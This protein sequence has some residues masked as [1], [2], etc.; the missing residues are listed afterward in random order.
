VSATRSEGLF[1]HEEVLLLSLKDKVGTLH[2]GTHYQHA[3]SAAIV[4]ELL[5][6]GR[7]RVVEDGTKRF[8]E[9]SDR[10][11]LGDDVLDECLERI[12]AAKRRG[13][14]RRWVTTFAGVRQLKRR[15]AESLVDRGILKIGRD[16]VLLVFSR[17]IYPERDPKPER[18]IVKRL[19]RAIFTP[20]RDIDPRTAV[21]AAIAHATGILPHVFDKKRL[22][23][24]KKR[25]KDLTDGSVVGEATR[26]VV[27]AMHA[28]VMVASVAATTA[29]AGR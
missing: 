27:Q 4:A 28:A 11:P 20:A 9:V 8:V 21:L 22:K 25:L 26:D 23:D 14:V 19:R 13:Q 24:R 2:F 17:T 29:A 7:I 12:A 6:G 3:M 15:V 1:L 18:E 16:K 5:L 10:T